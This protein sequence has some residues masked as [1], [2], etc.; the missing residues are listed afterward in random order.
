MPIMPL[1]SRHIPNPRQTS[2]LVG[3]VL[4][5]ALGGP[6]QAEKADRAKPM[7]VLADRSGT[8]DLRNQVSRFSG[9]VVITQGTMVIKA[10]R[11][12]IR[13][14]ADGYHAGTAWGASGAPVSY[15]QK[16]DGSAEFVEGQADRVE[17]DGKSEI[18]RFIGSAVVR[19]LRGGEAVDEVTGSLITWNHAEELFTVQGGTATAANPG[20]RV[21][22]VLAPSPAASDAAGRGVRAAPEGR[23]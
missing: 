4:W 9:S 13:Q 14:T 1:P 11:V 3:L 5:S 22:A 7:E 6:A 21:R 17:F 8:A 19:R 12:E 2:A 16:R 23:P 15:R 10:D 18:M 20:G